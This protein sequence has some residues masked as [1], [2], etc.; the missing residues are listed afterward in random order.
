[1]PSL[2]STVE[3][4]AELWIRIKAHA[5]KRAETYEFLGWAILLLLVSLCSFF[6]QSSATPTGVLSLQNEAILRV[7]LGASAA[8]SLSTVN[9][10]TSFMT[11][12]ATSFTD[13]AFP[14]DGNLRFTGLG[15]R[16]R[17][18]DGFINNQI[19]VVGS[20]R[21]RQVRIRSQNCSFVEMQPYT[22]DNCYAPL[23]SV[24]DIETDGLKPPWGQA[25]ASASQ[26]KVQDS[27]SRVTGELLSGGGYSVLWPPSRASTQQA[28]TALVLETATNT[29]WF[30]PSTRQV[31]LEFVA[32]NGNLN[33]LTS[34]KIVC[35]FT[36][37]GSAACQ[38]L[39]TTVSIHNL[40]SSSN[41]LPW[42][43][44][45]GA[46]FGVALINMVFLA[47]YATTVSLS[48]FFTR[49]WS[50]YD[51]IMNCLAVASFGY[52]VNTLVQFNKLAFP[53][54]VDEYVSY[55]YAVLNAVRYVE[56]LG[57]LVLM[58]WMRALKYLYYLPFT[59]RLY[60][61]LSAFAPQLGVLAL[62]GSV[63]TFA[64]SMAL[65]TL[66]G[67]QD[68]GFRDITTSCETLFGLFWP[69]LADPMTASKSSRFNFLVVLWVMVSVL[70]LWNL[71][72]SI[73]S[74]SMSAAARAAS[75]DEATISECI[76]IFFEACYDKLRAFKVYVIKLP[77]VQRML[78]R[79]DMDPV[80]PVNR[81]LEKQKSL[82]DRIAG[83]SGAEDAEA[84]SGGAD[85]ALRS[86]S[87]KVGE[88]YPG[89]DWN[90]SL[91]SAAQMETLEQQVREL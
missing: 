74:I 15:Y 34:A 45:Q 26:L 30:H 37:S 12:L 64:F 53:P 51:C 55:D 72:I 18:V 90:A 44:T 54:R 81:K 71:V 19:R 49:G 9:S 10:P 23:R 31:T 6:V 68:V 11:W 4:A 86:K 22:G 1:M 27:R 36:S 20:M 62:V 67:A 66:Y 61:T 29:S 65:T 79:L 57:I 52:Q 17:S 16:R 77:V 83:L 69:S 25:F 38:P 80:V 87:G 39:S 89:I 76:D 24:D 35:E 7:L 73:A 75:K 5:A 60:Y 40:I 14:I 82:R 84:E 59:L 43:I 48:F 63:I 13:A 46:V 78:R 41:S 28:A 56:V 47:R 2:L 42:V 70:L 91:V 33:A 3:A 8:N 32:F 50:F 21:L 85:A 58:I 88:M